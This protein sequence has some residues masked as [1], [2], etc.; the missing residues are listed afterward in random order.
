MPYP[1][2][3]RLRYDAP[4]VPITVKHLKLPFRHFIKNIQPLL[5]KFGAVK[6]EIKDLS[7]LISYKERLTN[8]EPIQNIAKQSFEATHVEGVYFL[9]NKPEVQNPPVLPAT[10]KNNVL[11]NH[12]LAKQFESLSID[13]FMEFFWKNVD[14]IETSYANGIPDSLFRQRRAIDVW[15]PNRLCTFADNLPRIFAQ[16]RQIQNIEGVTNSYIYLGSPASAFGLHVEDLLLYAFSYNDGPHAKIWVV[17]SPFYS[18]KLEK[19]LH[20]KFAGELKKCKGFIQHKSLILNPKFLEENNIAYSIVE[21]KANEIIILAPNTYHYG[22]NFGYNAA[23]AVNF[24]ST[25]WLE[26]IRKR[27]PK[28]CICYMYVFVLLLFI[29]IK[30]KIVF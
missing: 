30:K 23:E 29:K 17:I 3:Y 14:K 15:N 21:Q 28:P 7:D 10:Y 26:V 11:K 20:T 8:L 24:A 27:D 13:G 6:C 18:D 2:E 16:G 12:P 25:E 22:W 5:K 1:Y 19:L 9:M 4:S